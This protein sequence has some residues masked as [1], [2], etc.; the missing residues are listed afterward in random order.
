MQDSLTFLYDLILGVGGSYLGLSF[1]IGV[2]DL[3]KRS[4]P[5]YAGRATEEVSSA[6]EVEEIE[7]TP[8]PLELPATSAVEMDAIALPELKTQEQE[9][10]ELELEPV[11][12]VDE[13]E[14]PAPPRQLEM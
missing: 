6:T 7:E 14:A 10:E 3:W 12:L 11:E 2:V 4:S 8:V 1:V 9:E 13:L 5:D